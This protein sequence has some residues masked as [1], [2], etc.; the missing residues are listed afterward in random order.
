MEVD[1]MKQINKSELLRIFGGQ[2]KRK[3]KNY[4]KKLFDLILAK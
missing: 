3:K 1:E 2:Q 4:F